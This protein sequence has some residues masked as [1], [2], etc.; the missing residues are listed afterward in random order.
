MPGNLVVE[1][2][3]E[4]QG[5]DWALLFCNNLFAH[6]AESVKEIF[7]DGRVFLCYL[8]PNLIDALQPFDAA[9]GSTTVGL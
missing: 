2:I 9:Y 1:H 6:V 5:D 7:G 4:I 3:K 8:P